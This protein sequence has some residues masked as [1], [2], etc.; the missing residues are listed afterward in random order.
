MNSQ[1]KAE[2]YQAVV[3]LP[4][5]AALVAF[6]DWAASGACQDAFWLWMSANGRH[7]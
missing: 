7:V 1:Q 6:R 3:T 5:Y 4:S 2:P